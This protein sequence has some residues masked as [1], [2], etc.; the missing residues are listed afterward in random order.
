MITSNIKNIAKYIFIV[1]SISV[2]SYPSFLMPL[3]ENI[4]I[5]TAQITQIVGPK[6][7]RLGSTLAGLENA[8][9]Q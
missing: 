6:S 2:L 4:E 1:Y 3:S 7:E 9:T 5:F 8:V